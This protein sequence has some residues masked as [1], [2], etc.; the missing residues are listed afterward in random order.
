MVRVW[1]ILLEFVVW[2]QEFLFFFF[3]FYVAFLIM[4]VMRSWSLEIRFFLGGLRL[5]DV[6]EGM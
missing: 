1:G 2:D 4:D 3:L 6:F 5:V